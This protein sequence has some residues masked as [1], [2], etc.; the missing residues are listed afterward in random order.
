[1]DNDV[2]QPYSPSQHR[3]AGLGSDLTQL[4]NSVLKVIERGYR[5]KNHVLRPASVIVN[6]HNR[7]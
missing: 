4:E 7:A 5:W 6:V 2:G 3:L 1:M